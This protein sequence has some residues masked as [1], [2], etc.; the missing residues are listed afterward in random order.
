MRRSVVAIACFAFCLAVVPSAWASLNEIG[1]A[2]GTQENQYLAVWGTDTNALMTCLVDA[3][4]VAQG[5]PN[6][7][8]TVRSVNPAVAY[9]NDLNQFLVAW[10]ESADGM[11]FT[12]KCRI[13]TSSGVPSGDEI[14]IASD[15]NVTPYPKVVYSSNSQRYL[16]A[17]ATST[18]ICAQFVNGD[19]TLDGSIFDV[20]PGTSH[21][22]FA[23][24]DLPALAYDSVNHHFLILGL[25]HAGSMPPMSLYGAIVDDVDPV[26]MYKAPF[27]VLNSD[28]FLYPPTVAF[29]SANQRFLA[30]WEAYT[31]L[32]HDMHGQLISADGSL[33]GS[34]LAIVADAS[35][36]DGNDIVYKDGDGRYL[37]AWLNAGIIAQEVDADG[38]NFGDRFTLATPACHNNLKLAYNTVAENTM[39]AY[40]SA[41]F[42][43]G[44]VISTQ[45]VLA[46]LAVAID[47][48]DSA[49]LDELLT[50][51]ITVAN[52]GDDEA[53]EVELLIE[54]PDGVSYINTVSS[55]GV[56][57]Y[58]A[59][60]V[61]CDLGTIAAD[62]DATASLQ[63]I[64]TE[65]GTITVT[66][67]VSS[68]AVDPDSSNN[69]ASQETLVRQNLN[70]SP[71]EGTTGTV[72]EIL[73]TG[74]GSKKGKVT[75]VGSGKPSNLKVI[76][77]N[78]GGSGIIQAMVSKA[79]AVGTY[80]VSV[81]PKEPK[82]AS[83]LVE[84]GAFAVM[85]PEI[86]N[87][88][89]SGYI[90]Q[91]ITINGSCLGT[92]KGKVYLEYDNQGRISRKACKVLSWPSDSDAGTSIGVI[93]FTLPKGIPDGDWTLIVNNKVGEDS[94]PFAVTT[95]I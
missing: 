75:L 29:D 28:V 42:T 87:C 36:S 43:T 13:V 57:E 70:I 71:T 11:A 89:S 33:Y 58:D 53:T 17:M 93:Q 67:T 56:C 82:G 35:V 86:T 78:E 32:G 47:G 39:L 16:I 50:Y 4:G 92:R 15:L 69:S 40:S 41:I 84:E 66:A 6:T 55:Q 24:T 26:S 80:N 81:L 14:V 77:W 25:L 54:V 61:T 72:L 83:A 38:A 63:I 48:P 9:D 79:P 51:N 73:G 62:S 21:P 45:A 18:A 52:L 64:P 44:F 90:G 3:A 68:A 65:V 34:P 74:F 2:H 12:L 23:Y 85:A 22:G 59:G 91:I 1:A 20:I 8:T 46:D 95:N 7:L 10:T 31:G 37:V 5:T 60:V 27:S 88:P 49:I 19:G 30:I 76:S 94:V